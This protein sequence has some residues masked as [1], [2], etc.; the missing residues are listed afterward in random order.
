[1]ADVQPKVD[2]LSIAKNHEIWIRK[3]FLKSVAFMMNKKFSV[4]DLEDELQIFQ[5]VMSYYGNSNALLK[6]LLLELKNTLLS[7]LSGKF[8]INSLAI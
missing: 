7:L 6:A 3:K 8:L 2:F 1:M 4:M 5:F